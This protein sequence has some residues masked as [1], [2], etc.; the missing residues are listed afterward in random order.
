V[1]PNN[2]WEGMQLALAQPLVQEWVL[3]PCVHV[4]EQDIKHQP[5]L[6]KLNCQALGV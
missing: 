5:S 3:L 6:A 1:A 2:V 4:T